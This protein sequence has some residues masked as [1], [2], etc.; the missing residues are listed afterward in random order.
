M[1]LNLSNWLSTKELIVHWKNRHEKI[2]IRMSLFSQFWGHAKLGHIHVLST[3]IIC[4]YNLSILGKETPFLTFKSHIFSAHT[5]T[6]YVYIIYYYHPPCQTRCRAE[7]MEGK[8]QVLCNLIRHSLLSDY[9]EEYGSPNQRKDV[10]WDF[11]FIIFYFKK[12]IFS[13]EKE[14]VIN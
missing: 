7:K 6:F 10:W 2:N 12:I 9:T 8:K 11:F 5:W 13:K 4:Q 3:I 1:F 14:G